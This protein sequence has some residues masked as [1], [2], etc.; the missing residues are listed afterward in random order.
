MRAATYRTRGDSRVIEVLEVPTPGPGP[1]EVRVRLDVA[2]VNPT[3]WKVR[4]TGPGV[5]FD[6]Q[7]P[8][9][10]GAGVVEA[11]GSGVDPARIGERVWVYLAAHQRQW[12]TCAEYTV[13]PSRCAVALPAGIE[14]DQGAGLG[15]PFIT[16]HRCLLADGPI[17]GQTVLVAGG[18]G[19]VGNAAIQLA[20][21]AG[22]HVIATVSSPEKADIARDAGAHVVVN[23]RDSDAAQQIRTAARAGV[24]RII[25]VALG[26]NLA[27]DLQVITPHGVIVTY[28]SEA[29]DP[30]IPTRALM[31]QNVNL[32]FMLLYGLTSAMLAE[33]VAD[34]TAGLTEG[35]L[36]PLPSVRFALED[37][38]AAHDAVK[39]QTVGKVLIDLH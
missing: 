14:P 8:C 3:D 24:D 27:L 23:Y 1:G 9:H 29:T 38:A 22:A 5:T 32:S 10:D 28:A 21:R 17:D 4:E 39:A 19:A 2:G 37:A 13:V 16:A 30:T 33:A 20:R 18:A 25:E 11:V 34:I 7:V 12:G 36:Q 15:V 35:A 26:A 31:T 6:F